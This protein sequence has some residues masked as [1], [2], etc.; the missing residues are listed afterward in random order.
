MEPDAFG[1]CSQRRVGDGNRPIFHQT[2]I[3]ETV[4]A[5]QMLEVIPVELAARLQ[6]A[7]HL[8]QDRVLVG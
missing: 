1:A 6:Q 4:V 2:R 8:A 7:M 5:G 3:A